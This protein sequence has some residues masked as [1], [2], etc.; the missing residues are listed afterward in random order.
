MEMEDLVQNPKRTMKV[1]DLAK[2]T[3]AWD[4]MRRELRDAGGENM[5]DARQVDILAKMLP[6]ESKQHAL[7]KSDKFRD[8]PVVLRA[9]ME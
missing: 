2:G 6:A 1:G 7:W 9:W 5:S 4:I 8:N 3:V